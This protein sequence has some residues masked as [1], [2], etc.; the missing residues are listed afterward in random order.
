MKFGT[1]KCPEC[2]KQASGTLET[3]TGRAEFD[4]PDEDGNVE[5]SGETQ[6]FWDRQMTVTEIKN[7]IEYATLLCHGGHEW[8][9][10]VTWQG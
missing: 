9:S 7:E 2:G 6:I 4:E 3:V 5:Y 8:Q 1:M 10:T